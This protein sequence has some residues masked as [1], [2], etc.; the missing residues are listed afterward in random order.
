M[1]LMLTILCRNLFAG[2]ID[3]FFDFLVDKA[4]YMVGSYGPKTE[5]QSFSTQPE[6]TPSGLIS[7][8]TY[9]VKSKFTDDD[10]NV[11]LEWEWMFAVK[12]SWS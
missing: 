8:G 1:S 2:F 7:R 9:H 5:M 12:K 10:K 4:N 3:F 6:E 11:Y